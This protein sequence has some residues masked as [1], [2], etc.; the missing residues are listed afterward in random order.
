[1][2]QL[3]VYKFGGASVKDAEAVKNMYRIVTACKNPLVVVVSAM[4]KTTNL[5]EELHKA[6]IQ[7]QDIDSI[8]SDVLLYHRNIIAG[9]DINDD[10]AFLKL[11]KWFE[12]LL[13]LELKKEPALNPDFDY[14]RIVSFGELFSTAIISAYFH[15]QNTFHQWLDARKIIRTSSD[16]REG[17]VLWD[18][19][20]TM[21]EYNVVPENCQ[22]YITQGFL[23]STET[24]A[25]V[26][27]GR[28]GSDFS[29]AIFANAAKAVDMT[30]WKDVPGIMN[31]D[32]RWYENA[33]LIQEMT[34][35]EAVEM[36]YFGANV[37]HPKTLK[38]LE[39]ENIPLYVRSFLDPEQK[40]SVIKK[41]QT[42]RNLLP[43]LIKKQQQAL[44]TIAPKDFSFMQ[45]DNLRHV[46]EAFE[47]FHITVNIMEKAAL[48]FTACV[49]YRNSNLQKVVDYLSETFM[50]RYNK[51]L[52]L[53]TIRHY[54]HD[55]ILDL[56]ENMEVL[57]EQRNRDTAW[58]VYK[59]Q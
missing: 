39:N 6:Y 59:M 37:I 18:L 36:S 13:G 51:E 54:D 33:S 47:K 14:D 31:A 7:R 24:N 29:A 44:I 42:S 49:G 17:R 55:L 57:M 21:V 32:P 35:K 16:Y 5:L 53:L 34:Y 19:T 27:L 12:E 46:F 11:Y 15:A 2:S 8:L 52:E 41:L 43:V 45:E 50:V 40:G 25:T 30:I 38:P 23:G 56:T 48:S 4:G 1:M 10:F 22:L 9:L 28:E 20:K 3:K 26:T 58:F